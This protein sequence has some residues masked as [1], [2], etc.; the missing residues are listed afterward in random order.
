MGR[1]ILGC[2]SSGSNNPGPGGN[3][4]ALRARLRLLGR[5]A[6]LVPLPSVRRHRDFA[7]LAPSSLLR[8]EVTAM[9]LPEMPPSK[10]RHRRCRPPLLAERSVRK[11]SFTPIR[12]EAPAGG[13]MAYG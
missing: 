11:G 4:P 2:F 1:A 9:A 10:D 6:A 13:I 12:T 5:L 3:G 8:T 7:V